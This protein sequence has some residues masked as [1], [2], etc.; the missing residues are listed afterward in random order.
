[1]MIFLALIAGVVIVLIFIGLYNSLIKK[2]NQV[3]NAF[4]SVDVQLKKR[5][6]LI[7]NLVS[8]VKN[9]ATHEKETLTKLTELRSKAINPNISNDEKIQL[10]KETKQM[11]GNIM[12]MVENYP[13]LKANEN[14]MQLQRSLN[15]TEEQ[16]SASRRYYNTSVTDFNNAIM[17]FPSN[18]VAGIMGL[19]EEKFFEAEETERQNVDVGKLFH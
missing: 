3:K 4:A 10:E 6:D 18:L 13:D 2:K 11:L 17:V 1:M 12:V 16:I 15:E 14:F 7:P 19:K 9:Y 5:Y 8:T